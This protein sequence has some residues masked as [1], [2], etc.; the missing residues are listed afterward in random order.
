MIVGP[1]QGERHTPVVEVPLPLPEED[2][3]EREDWEYDHLFTHTGTG[4]TGGDSWCDVE[5]VESTAPELLG[6]TF[7]FGY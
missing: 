4:R 6:L 3:A 1:T 7:E 5:I 2:S